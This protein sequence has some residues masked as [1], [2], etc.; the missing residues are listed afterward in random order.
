MLRN[1]IAGRTFV[2][3]IN[4]CLLYSCVCLALER[5]TIEPTERYLIDISNAALNFVRRPPFALGLCVHV[6]ETFVRVVDDPQIF[7]VE[8]LV[9]VGAISLTIYLKDILNRL[10]CALAFFGTNVVDIPMSVTDWGLTCWRCPRSNRSC[11]DHAGPRGLGFQQ[12]VQQ[13][14][15][16]PHGP[17]RIR[18]GVKSAAG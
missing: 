4:A 14:D 5:R 9:K 12:I 11:R 15:P 2:W 6:C 8:F 13:L 3:I 18:L 17:Y 7:V 10:D 1:L 16:V